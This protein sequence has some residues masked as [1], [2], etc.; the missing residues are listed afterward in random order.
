M[1][2]TWSKIRDATQETSLYQ[3]QKKVGKMSRNHN[4]NHNLS[5]E[6]EIKPFY[7]VAKKLESFRKA[8]E[9]EIGFKKLNCFKRILQ[10]NPNDI[11]ELK[12]LPL[13]EFHTQYNK[14]RELLEN[15]KEDLDKD[16]LRLTASPYSADIQMAIELVGIG[17]NPLIVYDYGKSAL[18]T[19]FLNME[20]ELAKYFIR[21]RKNLFRELSDSLEKSNEMFCTYLASNIC[22]PSS[23]LPAFFNWKPDSKAADKL[24][25]EVT[26]CLENL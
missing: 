23:P 25:K 22:D 1:N 26:E 18:S 7:D 2:K 5:I 13:T 3:P 16:L 15:F 11:L 17:A 8:H 19:A 14:I 10:L 6:R 20:I 21:S 4:P 9:N 12:N 24:F